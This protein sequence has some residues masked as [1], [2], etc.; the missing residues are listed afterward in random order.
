MPAAPAASLSLLKP[1][2]CRGGAAGAP[3]GSDTYSCG[4]SAPATPPLLVMVHVTVATVSN[5]S[6][7]PPGSTV[8]AAGPDLAVDVILMSEKVKLV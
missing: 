5:R 3:V 4:T 7:R 2:S 8:P 6:A 1:R